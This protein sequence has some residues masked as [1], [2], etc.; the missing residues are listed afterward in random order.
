M[1]LCWI[2]SE[3]EQRGTVL[4]LLINVLTHNADGLCSDTLYQ[5]T[6]QECTLEGKL[7]ETFC[8]ELKRWDYV[9]DRLSACLT[10]L[11]SITMCINSFPDDLPLLPVSND[12]LIRCVALGCQRQ[13]CCGSDDPSTNTS[14]TGSA[15]MSVYPI[16]R[17]REKR[18]LPVLSQLMPETYEFIALIPQHILMVIETGIGFKLDFYKDFLISPALS[19]ESL[20]YNPDHKENMDRILSIS[21]KIWFPT[22]KRIRATRPSDRTF[23][24]KALALWQEFG[25]RL[26]LREV[27]PKVESLGHVL[28]CRWRD[29][30][31]HEKRVRCHRM[32]VCKGCWKA[33]YCGTKCQRLDWTEGGHRERCDLS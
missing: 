24:D 33:L 7:Y 27:Q 8:A 14:I 10:L 26:E 13:A 6:I 4:D 5:E 3:T 21:R 20:R 19:V 9:D 29:C 16:F 17:Y 2:F 30:L 11:V 28:G 31:C 1:L 12:N 18:G 15:L 22:L 25:R 32:K 23:R